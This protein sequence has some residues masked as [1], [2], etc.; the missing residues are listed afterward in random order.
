L[1]EPAGDGAVAEEQDG[2]AGEEMAAGAEIGG[3]PGARAVLVGE[4]WGK[5]A[6]V[7]EHESED[8]LGA[9]FV[10]NGGAVGGEGVSAAEGVADVGTVV[11]RVA[12][13]AEMDPAEAGEIEIREHSEISALDMFR[14]GAMGV[15]FIASS[16]LLGSD[17]PATNPRIATVASPF[18][19]RSYTAVEAAQPDVA[20]IHAHSA[21]RHGNVQ[22]DAAHWPDND[23][24][25][26]V[27]W[28]GKT[29]IVTVE[30]LV[31]DEAVREHP[32]RT[33]LPRDVVTCVVEAPYGAY[34]CACDGRYTYDLSFIGEYYAASAEPDEF[35]RHLDRWVLGA[36]DHAA[37]LDL[38]GLKR[39]LAI[40]TRGGVL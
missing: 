19:G 13:A 24:D 38:V 21:D 9:G 3:G 6:G 37:F 33:I 2:L 27:G 18:S 35:R 29:T 40:A 25:V 4:G 26:Y 22:L 8:V 7:G 34:P 1:G 31:S 36:E 10:V 20:V 16:V 5:S 28:A 32:E 23:A 11:A 14:A 30:Q 39:L 15:P 12:G 17:V